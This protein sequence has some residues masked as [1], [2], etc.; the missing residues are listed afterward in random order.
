MS[1]FYISPITDRGQHIS[2]RDQTTQLRRYAARNDLVFS[3]PIVEWAI[4]GIYYR[5]FETIALAPNSSI[6]FLR[7]DMVP[8]SATTLWMSLVSYLLTHHVRL[9]SLGID[10]GSSVYLS[11][12]GWILRSDGSYELRVWLDA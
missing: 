5:L 12:E 6:Y 9:V 10:D 11:G 3:L 7:R 2:V 8:S 4:P 1:N